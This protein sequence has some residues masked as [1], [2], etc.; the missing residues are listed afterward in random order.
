[1]LGAD[2]CPAHA[3]PLLSLERVAKRFTGIAAVGDVSFTIDRGQVGGFLAPNDAGKSTV[4][5]RITQYFEPDA[6]HI[7]MADRHRGKRPPPARAISRS[8]P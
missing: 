4:T 6:G 8:G 3:M 7:T 2:E 5:R 1:M